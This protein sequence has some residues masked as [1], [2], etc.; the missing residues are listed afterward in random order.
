[1]PDRLSPTD[2][3]PDDVVVPSP[4]VAREIH[5]ETVRDERNR[6]LKRLPLVAL[7]ILFWGLSARWH[8]ETLPFFVVGLS[9]F[10]TVNAGIEWWRFRNADPVEAVRAD[11]LQRLEQ[12]RHEQRLLSTTLAMTHGLVGAIGAVWVFQILT[13]GLDRSVFVAGL[14]K[15]AV[16]AGQWWR[17][18]TATYLHGSLWHFWGNMAALRGLGGTIESYD[19]RLRLPLVYLL[20]ALGGSVVSTAFV[21]KISVGASGG[22]MGLCGYLLMLSRHQPHIAP[23]WIRRWM[24]AAFSGTA[25]L[26]LLGFFFIDNFAHIGGALT[27]LLC[28]A[29]MIPAEGQP[30]TSGRERLLDAL[31]WIAAAILLGGA[32]FTVRRLISG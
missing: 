14:V 24:I 9:V 16:R 32:A 13:G 1:V 4:G 23:P 11:R 3:S 27:G 30:A 19:R 17:L 31:G 12:D 7:A 10:W 5:R 18:L 15:P 2:P 6:L 25:V 20:A 22:I 28:G 21:A 29:V 8:V 26:G